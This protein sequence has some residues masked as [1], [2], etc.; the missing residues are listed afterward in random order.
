MSLLYSSSPVNM[1]EYSVSRDLK[2]ARQDSLDQ[3][4]KRRARQPQ[5]LPE[6]AILLRLRPWRFSR[7]AFQPQKTR[8]T[9]PSAPNTYFWL[10]DAPS[11][12]KYGMHLF[13]DQ[14]LY[15]A[16]SPA[17]ST[18]LNSLWYRRNLRHSRSCNYPSTV[19]LSIGH[20]QQCFASW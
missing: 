1:P 12:R 17:L 2:G 3:R 20:Q 5:K 13:G 7:P 19:R 11:R 18:K 9:L 6:L 8:I 14:Q 10:P 16:N 4:S 15:P